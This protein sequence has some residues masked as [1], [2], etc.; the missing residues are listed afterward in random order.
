MLKKIARVKIHQNLVYRYP[1]YLQLFV[2]TDKLQ[3]HHSPAS[4]RYRNSLSMNS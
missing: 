2:K 4:A 3:S 1:C